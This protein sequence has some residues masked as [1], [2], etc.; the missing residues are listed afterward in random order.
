MLARVPA[1]GRDGRCVRGAVAR[2]RGG[3]C[4]GHW[5]SCAVRAMPTRARRSS[6]R[7]SI[8]S[9]ICVTAL[10]AAVLGLRRG[11]CARAP[12]GAAGPGAGD[13]RMTEAIHRSCRRAQ[14]LQR[15]H[16]QSPTRCCT[17]STSSLQPGEFAALIGPSGSG[18]STLLNIIGLLERPTAGRYRAQAGAI[19][20]LARRRAHRAA[21]PTR[22]VSC[23]SSTTCCRRS[24]RWRT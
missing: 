18:K 19:R 13:P 10:A 2:A 21:R 4:A 20:T 14:D 5:C 6:S 16:A 3:G 23:S 24:R 7:I 22:S 15:G 12:R 17:A 8:P 11:G 9:C 1:A